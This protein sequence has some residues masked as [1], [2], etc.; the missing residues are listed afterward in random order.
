MLPINKQSGVLGWWVLMLLALPICLQAQNNFTVKGSIAENASGNPIDYATVVLKSAD[1]TRFGE[2]V[3][4]LLSS[5][6][7]LHSNDL[8]GHQLPEKMMTHIYV[9]PVV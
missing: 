9:L 5:R 8:L 1:R 6:D 7:I 2:H 4:M 3:S